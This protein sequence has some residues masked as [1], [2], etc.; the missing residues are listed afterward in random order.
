MTLF[1]EA[2]LLSLIYLAGGVVKGAL[3]FGLPLV[4]I[5]ILPFLL[6]VDE[7]LAYNAVVLLVTNAIQVIRSGEARAAFRIAAPILAAT[8][9]ATPI[10]AGLAT[11][12]PTHVLL[13]L[14]GA[15]VIAFSLFG[16]LERSPALPESRVSA[17]A[18]GAVGGIVGAFTSAP[19][20]VFVMYLVSLRM[21]R[22]LFMGVMGILMGTVGVLLS[23]SFAVSGTLTPSRAALGLLLVL[24]GLA[25]FMIGDRVAGRLPELRFRQI[26][27]LVL[28]FL[29]ALMIRRSLGAG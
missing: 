7:A 8:A 6:P 2:A 26:V 17:A 20:P 1:A 11:L 9:I 5:S 12:L 27:L 18:V 15:F 21:A 14:L 4:T 29:G 16:L 28:L 13:G 25:G 23:A 19:G 24:P 10:G 3:G 22:T